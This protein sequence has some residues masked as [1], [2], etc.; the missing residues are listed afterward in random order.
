MQGLIVEDDPEFAALVAR[1]L[2]DLRI[3][4]TICRTSKAAEEW[5]VSGRPDIVVIDGVLPDRSGFRLAE[6]VCRSFGTEVPVVFV[7]A[8]FRDLRSFR[9]L[10]AMGVSSVLHKPMSASMLRSELQSQLGLSSEIREV[11]YDTN[12]TDSEVRRLTT[13]YA[14]KL[15]V[16]YAVEFEQLMQESTA[17][18]SQAIARLMRF[19]HRLAGTAG[20]FGQMEVSDVARRIEHRLRERRIDAIG[21]DLRLLLRL[22]REARSPD[23]HQRVLVRQ[24]FEH[25]AVA[26]DARGPLEAASAQLTGLGVRHVRAG[27]PRALLE[28]LVIDTPD[29]VVLSALS[30]EVRYLGVLHAVA[31]TTPVLH[32][33]PVPSVSSGS[34]VATPLA[35]GAMTRALSLPMIAPFANLRV[36]MADDDDQV[37]RAAKSILQPLGAELRHV[38]DVE[39]FVHALSGDP[40][41]LILMDVSM[42]FLN[43][44][45]LCKLAKAE[46]AF[47]DVPVYFLSARFGADDRRTAFSAGGSSFL[48]KPL[49]AA[50]L[51]SIARAVSRVKRSRRAARALLDG[52]ERIETLL[53]A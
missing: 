45:E 7:S 40:V 31:P 1:V 48:M 22:M 14:E 20:T 49:V 9:R 53:H 52:R 21:E 26:G 46:P 41:D 27:T 30:N 33:G 39:S 24:R 44:Y 37:A 15:V 6:R 23:A 18:N 34:H 8:F 38:S 4:P 3:E 51:A 13:A 16:T 25:I 32:L 12:E 10:K 47:R 43:G 42:P 29:C 19:C 28:S 17:G 2:R 5:L 50:E 36:L 11:V 35:T